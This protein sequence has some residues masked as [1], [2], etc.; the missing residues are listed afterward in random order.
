MTRQEAVEA[1][2]AGKKVTHS[3]FTADEFITMEN[4]NIKTILDEQGYNLPADE[5]WEL[6]QQPEWDDGWSIVEDVPGPDKVSPFEV[7]DIQDVR[8]I[9]KAKDKHWSILANK[10]NFSAE[11][12][13]HFRVE[14]LKVLLEMQAHVIV[15]TALEDLK[16]SDVVKEFLSNN[17][18]RIN[19]LKAIVELFI[20]QAIKNKNKEEN[21]EYY[22]LSHDYHIEKLQLL[23][24]KLFTDAPAIEEEMNRIKTNLLNDDKITNLALKIFGSS[25][26]YPSIAT[27]IKEWI[28]SQIK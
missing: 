24:K 22:C 16:N 4:G 7:E 17:E 9:I 11:E 10:E 28:T 3:T 23:H 14:L 2:I 27:M 21:P 19:N 13:K 25:V 5:F 15:D 26:P 20:E 6:R 12:A 18:T 8:I 1:M